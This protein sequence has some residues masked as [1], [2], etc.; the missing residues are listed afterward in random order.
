[1]RPEY[2][3]QANLVYYNNKFMEKYGAVFPISIPDQG[4]IDL[5]HISDSDNYALAEYLPV[6]EGL[7]TQLKKQLFFSLQIIEYL[8]KLYNL[9][10][11]RYE[12]GV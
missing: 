10:L 4:Y 7:A 2:F 5:I 6:S 3:T 8:C 9:R 11:E 12:L 1:M